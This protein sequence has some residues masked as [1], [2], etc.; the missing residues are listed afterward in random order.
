M[1]LKVAEGVG[2]LN[3]NSPEHIQEL[4]INLIRRGRVTTRELKVLTGLIGMID[5]AVAQEPPQRSLKPP[6]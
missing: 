6:A 4:L 3:E 5:R 1:V 2:F